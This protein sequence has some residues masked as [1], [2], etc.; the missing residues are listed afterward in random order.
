M[1]AI[2]TREWAQDVLWRAWKFCESPRWAERLLTVLAQRGDR[3]LY[4]RIYRSN[5]LTFVGLTTFVGGVLGTLTGLVSGFDA[6]PV[7]PIPTNV[8]G[9]LSTFAAIS[10]IA[11]SIFWRMAVGVGG[12]IGLVMAVVA[13]RERDAAKLFP[14]FGL[15]ILVSVVPHVSSATPITRWTMD[16]SHAQHATMLGLLGGGL[17]GLGAV[18][19]WRNRQSQ[20]ERALCWWIRSD[21]R[22]ADVVEALEML[23]PSLAREL[24]NVDPGLEAAVLRDPDFRWGFDVN[25][26]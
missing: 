8:D 10:G 11:G 3:S 6:V 7:V 15:G 18:L 4:N 13:I 20:P 9:A 5:L 21:P 19:L 24:E 22:R 16:W 2:R 12:L 14:V 17:L 1:K 23:E 26:A 25:E